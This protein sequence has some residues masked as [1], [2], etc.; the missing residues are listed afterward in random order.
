ML[1]LVTAGLPAQ[2]L[3]SARSATALLHAPGGRLLATIAPGTELRVVETRGEYSRVQLRGFIDTAF[4]RGRRDTFPNSVGGRGGTVRMRAEASRNARLVADLNVGMGLSSMKRSGGF[5][6]VERSGWVRSVAL[7][8]ASPAVRAATRE[9]EG[10][11]PPA[12]VAQAVSANQSSPGS[13]SLTPA[14][15]VD[16]RGAPGGPVLGSA[17]NGVVMTPLARERGWVRVQVEVW[18]PER[19]V[20]SADPAMRLSPSAADLRADPE[21]SRGRTVSWAVQ[22]LAL[23]YADPLR[24]DLVP[25]EPYLLA[26]GPG[27]ESALLYLAVPPSLL[28]TAKSLPPLSEVTVTARVRNARSEPVGVPVLDLLRIVQ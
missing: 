3:K 2:A 6:A 16:L 1:A 8:G 7:E 24:R 25:D 14:R 21:G 26:R 9:P 17:R 22:V 12:Q 23:Q 11:S 27:S 13:S 10:G 4:V 18:V 15:E 20:V 5:A 19:E 28:A